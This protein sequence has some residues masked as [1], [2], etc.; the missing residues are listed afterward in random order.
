MS[1]QADMLR[2]FCQWSWMFFYRRKHNETGKPC[3]EHLNWLDMVLH[4]I[5]SLSQPPSLR[6][7]SWMYADFWNFRTGQ[8]SKWHGQHRWCLTIPRHPPRLERQF[9]EP[10]LHI[11][12]A[13]WWPKVRIRGSINPTSTWPSYSQ[14][15]LGSAFGTRKQPNQIDRDQSVGGFCRKCS[16]ECL[17]VR[18][19]KHH[20][21][22]PISDAIAPRPSALAFNI[23]EQLWQIYITFLKWSFLKAAY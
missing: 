3:L 10:G 9:G 2:F 23:F 5:Q 19:F 22:E 4:V 21:I 7:I 20:Y 1:P 17:E 18:P 15:C 14:R 16:G 12:L 13:C 11:D 6:W 8:V